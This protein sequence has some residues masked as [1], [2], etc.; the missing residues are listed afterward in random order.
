MTCSF[1]TEHTMISYKD[2]R[3]GVAVVEWETGQ[4]CDLLLSSLTGPI[5]LPPISG[6]EIT[7]H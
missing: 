7:E 3:R 4:N 5:P 6:A 2:Q 1:S